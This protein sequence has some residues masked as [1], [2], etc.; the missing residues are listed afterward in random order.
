M[1]DWDF[2]YEMKERG[3]SESEIQDAMA[4]GAASWE[5]RLY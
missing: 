3:Y 1:S 4:S 5:W 2:L